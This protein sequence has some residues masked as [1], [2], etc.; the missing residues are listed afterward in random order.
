MILE[1]WGHTRTTS[2]RSRRRRVTPSEAFARRR[3][4]DHRLVR[5]AMARAGTS[6]HPGLQEPQQVRRAISPPPSPAA[7]ASS[8]VPTRPTSQYDEAIVKNLDLDFKWSSPAGRPPR[9]RPSGGAGEEGVADRLLLRAAVLHA[10][11]PLNGS[12]C[13]RTPKA[14]TPTRQTSRATTP[15]PR[16]RRSSAPSS[17]SRTPRRPRSPTPTS[18]PTMTRTWSPV[19]SPPTACLR[20]TRPP[21]GSRRTRTRSRPGCPRPRLT[22]TAFTTPSP[23]ERRGRARLSGVSACDHLSRL[24]LEVQVLAGWQRWSSPGLS[25]LPC[26]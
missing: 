18:G 3:H 23:G 2:R 4:R 26:A 14:A 16:S 20:R 24:I 17:Q 13:R 21:S 25:P 12:R 22:R 10:E 15:R 1:E 19:T 6:G 9:S 7:R 5:P 11:V 8:S